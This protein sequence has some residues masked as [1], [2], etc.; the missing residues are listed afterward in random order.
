MFQ[1]RLRLVDTV[2]KEDV[3]EAIRLMEMSKDSLNPAHEMHSRYEGCESA[4]F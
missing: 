4:V 2:E 3:N 1:A